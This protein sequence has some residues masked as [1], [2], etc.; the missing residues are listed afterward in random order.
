M[1]P[2]MMLALSACATDPGAL[3][4]ST[5]AV[6]LGLIDTT[7][8]DAVVHEIEL[9]NGGTGPLALVAAEVVLTDGLEVALDHAL[10]LTLG[11]GETTPLQVTA[12]PLRRGLGDATVRVYADDPDTPTRDLLLHTEALAPEA[13]VEGADLL[14]YGA[15][16]D[17]S[18]T[19]T[20]TNRGD[21]TLRLEGVWAESAAGDLAIQA[22]SL[23]Q[24]LA[25]G[26]SQ[27]LTLTVPDDW[28]S[29]AQID[30]VVATNDVFA[31]QVRTPIDTVCTSEWVGQIFWQASG[32]VDVLVVADLSESS[33]QR[34]YVDQLRDELPE[35][36]QAWHDSELDLRLG[37]VL[38]ADGGLAWADLAGSPE[39]LASELDGW[40]APA[41][42][43][44]LT[45][46]PF[47]RAQRALAEQPSF[48][49][50]GSTLMVWMLDSQDRGSAADVTAVLEDWS[51]NL[52]A[53]EAMRVHGLVADAGCDA[54]PTD[55]AVSAAV[56]LT[57]GLEDG[58]CDDSYLP[59]LRGI[60]DQHMEPVRLIP[61]PAEPF[62][63]SLRVRMN[64]I[65][66]PLESLAYEQPVLLVDEGVEWGPGDYLDI[67]YVIDAQCLP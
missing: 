9:Q 3:Q 23:A 29:D 62:W 44:T 61:L 1:T 50:T 14:E 20:L 30:V 4:L 45:F 16:C 7:T 27:S 15:G 13:V 57:G 49:R 58:I 54:P 65:L 19:G 21:R 67:K 2:L 38:D 48:R 46:E 60:V 64:S 40:L 32:L 63:H 37:A 31:P 22:G 41:A 26:E 35:A 28:Y 51:R 42:E 39:T 53:A 59:W 66:L 18:W 55:G 56:A 10:P 43:T 8:D 17:Q 24:T 47:D 34:I 25:P 52:D 36:L 33:D 11:A 5:G 6:D 12:T